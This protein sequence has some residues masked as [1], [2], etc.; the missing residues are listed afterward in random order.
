MTQKGL[1]QYK[2]KNWTLSSEIE[3]SVVLEKD[4]EKFV[5]LLIEQ[6]S[7]VTPEYLSKLKSI[8]HMAFPSQD[9]FKFFKKEEKNFFDKEEKNVSNKKVVINVERLEDNYRFTIK[10]IKGKI[11][12]ISLLEAWQRWLQTKDNE[13]L[14]LFN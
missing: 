7:Y 9:T 13:L 11:Q 4:I 12:L 6:F 2:I 3:E 1:T 5:E 14:D 8:E 10:I